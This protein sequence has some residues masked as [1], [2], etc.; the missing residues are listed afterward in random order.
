MNEKKK[1]YQ[2]WWV[3]LLAALAIAAAIL[4]IHQY[5]KLQ[6]TPDEPASVPE[7]LKTV[8]IQDPENTAAAHISEQKPD[9]GADFTAAMEIV[10]IGRS[11]EGQR[12]DALFRFKL[13]AGILAEQ[14]REAYFYI[15]YQAGDEPTLRA[16]AMT[17]SWYTVTGTWNEAGGSIANDPNP[18]TA[19][20]EAGDWY[21]IDVT[22]LVQAWLSGK[23][24]NNGF[25]VEE[26]VN[27]KS[28]SFYSTINAELAP[29]NCPK[30]V[31]TYAE[32]TAPQGG[33][34]G[35]YDYEEQEVGNCFSYALRDHDM[36][37]YDDLFDTAALQTAYDAGGVEGGLAYVKAQVAQYVDLHKDALQIAGMRELPA[38]NASIS[39]DEYRI[40]LRIGFRDRSFQEGIQVDEDF[41]YH[42]WAQMADG[43]W[44][45]KTPQ[46]N[47]R[48]VPGSS[49]ATDP[50]QYPWHQG[51]LWGYDK[52]N[53]YYTSDVVYF[54]VTKAG[55]GFTAHKGGVTGSLPE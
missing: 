48:L 24:N 28:A 31:I 14:L 4:A 22:A 9:E 41:D 7:N 36:I 13:P 10:E 17:Q 34:L 32:A 8:T 2:K 39:A 52:W 33:R 53:D 26:A 11:A 12:S 30:L 3:W 46:E 15:R 5:V 21:K 19:T 43:T 6:S 20:K 45:E 23:S 55:Q 47:S 35:K 37:L 16:V 27:G 1:F 18:A 25:A 49:A 54:A 51:Y 29:E 44:A 42:F 50:G 38:Y 40:A